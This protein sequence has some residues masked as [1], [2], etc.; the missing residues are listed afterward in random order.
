[1]SS[2]DELLCPA[3]SHGD[4]WNIQ[5]VFRVLGQICGIYRGHL[6]CWDRMWNIQRAFRVLGQ[7]CGIYRG[8]LECW[9]RFVEYTEGI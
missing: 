1:M 5:R 9:D 4:V 3:A 8:H 2:C 6:E 7:I